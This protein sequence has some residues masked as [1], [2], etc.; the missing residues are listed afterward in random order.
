M[1]GRPVQVQAEF[2]GIA[3]LSM[4]T[5][6][7]QC[8]RWD[9]SQGCEHSTLCLGAAAAGQVLACPRSRRWCCMTNHAVGVRD[10]RSAAGVN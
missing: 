10:I 3:V 1:A 7:S 5:V 6:R 2:G 8:L 9:G 4:A